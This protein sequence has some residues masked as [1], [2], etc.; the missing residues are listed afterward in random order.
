MANK[1]A[2]KPPKIGGSK[3]YVSSKIVDALVQSK[4]HTENLAVKRS[5]LKEKLTSLPKERIIDETKPGILAHIHR[6]QT[7]EQDEV[8]QDHMEYDDTGFLSERDDIIDDRVSRLSTTKLT[9][10]KLELLQTNY[11]NKSREF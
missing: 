4:M 2:S 10:E 1:K 8:I 6:S 9:M 11:L 5:T 7:T 3:I